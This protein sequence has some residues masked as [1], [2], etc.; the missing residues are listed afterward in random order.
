MPCRRWNSKPPFA[1]AKLQHGRDAQ[2]VMGGEL[3]EDAWPQTQQLLSAGDVVQIRHRLAGE[4]GIAVEP[5]L[6]RA[7]D[8]GVPI[9]ALDQPHHQLAVVRP[10]ERIDIVDHVAGAL[11]IGL[12]REAKSVPT[13]KRGIGERCR[14]HVEGQFQP[15]GFLGVDGEVEIMDLGA[16]RQVQQLRHQLGH[17]TVAAD[18]LEAR[19]QRRQL[20][21]DAGPIGQGMAARRLADSQNRAGIGV[22]ISPCVGGGAG[23]FAEHVEGIALP[24]AGARPGPLQGLRDGLPQHEMI[25]HQPHRLAR[26]GAHGGCAQP[27]H[28]PADGAIG[29]LAGLD[30]PRRE[31]QCPGRGVD[32]EGG[33]LGLVVDEVAL[34]ELVL[35]E[36]VGG[37]RVRHAQQGLGQHHQGQPFLGRERKFP[38]HI[39]DSTKPVVALADGF[40]QPRRGAIDPR[41]LRRAEMHRWQK[42]RGDIGVIGRVGGG[43]GRRNVRHGVSCGFNSG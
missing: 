2:R 11:L 9:G 40:D 4:H 22:E 20:D 21:G 31:A 18:C 14:N 41:L 37:A 35:D 13:G 16:L 36:L 7:L 17:H 10:G 1:P 8:L 28:Q 3:R 27:L 15:V 6:L 23:A 24:L 33:G 12:D 38:Q 30:H 43:E 39:L 34:A 42:A 29:R 5:A 26:G 19:M 25:S 32:Q